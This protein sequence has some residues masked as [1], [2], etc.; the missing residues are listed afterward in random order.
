MRRKVFIIVASVLIVAT[1][2]TVLT[3][4]NNKDYVGMS[5]LSSGVKNA[6]YGKASATAISAFEEG[7][8]Y[9]YDGDIAFYRKSVLTDAGQQT[10]YLAYSLSKKAVIYTGNEMPSL[11]RQSSGYLL[12]QDVYY[13]VQSDVEDG[14]T[15]TFYSLSGVLISGVPNDGIFTSSGTLASGRYTEEYGLDLGN[16]KVIKKKGDSYVVE[17]KPSGIV[18][19][20]AESETIELENYRI[21]FYGNT[22][23]FAVLDKNCN[24]IRTVAA[25]TVTGSQS[26]DMKG[27]SVVVLP[28]DKILFQETVLLPA[29]T[30]KDYDYY[31]N[32]YYCKFKTFVYDADKDKTKEIK[33]CDYVFASSGS[34]FREAG[35]TLCRVSE[36][37]DEKLLCDSYL[38][39]FDGDLNVALD[40]QAKL[41]GATSFTL[42][43]DYVKIS[44][45]N[46]V[47]YY[48]GDDLV[49]EVPKGRMSASET[50][51]SVSDMFVSSDGR[52]LYN[53][54]GTEITSL[55]K[56]G[57]SAFVNLS[58][59]E[60]FVY[61]LKT[62][63]DEVSGLNETYLCR[64]ER[65]SGVITKI[66]CTTDYYLLD[67]GYI[68]VKDPENED[69]Y[70]LYDAVSYDKLVE[71]FVSAY[72]EVCEL[73]TG[74]VIAGSVEDADGAYKAVYYAVTR[75]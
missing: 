29:N 7:S 61:F 22:G 12:W 39:G 38:Q 31:F 2:C 42:I 68:L 65:N 8:L 53:P 70:E 1:L 75:E 50:Y 10:E 71:G 27:V 64:Y 55:E 20:F 24:L 5:A 54:D 25:S 60:N 3:A 63:K 69:T 14:E 33:D 40:I 32:D 23:D 13:T 56:L 58:Y 37:S 44:N 67:G 28:D 52:T 9:S 35:V 41:P 19:P 36:I 57:A 74:D 26:S 11:I 18:T 17:D 15:L 66:G 72:V 46:R 45:D 59:S 6:A 21:Y 73:T 47:Q 34:Y 62:E 16:G 51:L 43:G 48:K 4:C 30:T 49:L